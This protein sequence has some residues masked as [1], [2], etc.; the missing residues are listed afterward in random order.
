MGAICFF[1]GIIIGVVC[2]ARSSSTETV[3]QQIVQYLGFVCAS[4]FI[5]GGVIIDKL[6]GICKAHGFILD[7]LSSIYRVNKK[8]DVPAERGDG[9]AEGMSE[10]LK[11]KKE[12]VEKVEDGASV[13]SSKRK[14]KSLRK[15]T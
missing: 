9:D 7:S 14:N 4:I 3:M 12:N 5:V 13:K 1:V 8:T 11:S 6:G 2:F 10:A 15:I